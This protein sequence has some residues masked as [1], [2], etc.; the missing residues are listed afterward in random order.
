MEATVDLE[1]STG[2]SH[3][4]VLL[5][6]AIDK[7]VDPEQLGKL[8]DLA[9]RWEANRA[10]KEFDKAMSL[11]QSQMPAILR[12]AENSHTR[13]R[14]ARFESLNAVIRPIYT[15]HG[16]SISFTEEDCPVEG[17]IRLVLDIAH[18]GGCTRRKRIDI[19]LD[20][21]GI[22]GNDNMTATQG[23][24]ST[25]SYAK[26]GLMKMVFNLAETDEDQDGNS[27]YVSP[28][29]IQ[30]INDL[31]AEYQDLSDK[32]VNIEKFLA[33]LGVESLDRLD[34]KGYQKAIDDLK[35]K[36]AAAKREVA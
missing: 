13:S 27:Q 18:E 16:F 17:S 20:G 34:K 12:D 15:K 22:K 28:D 19:P 32:K 30:E 1:H 25:I 3:P 10:S 29:Q 31:I 11:C 7:G 6:A 9:E 5:Q 33:W 26:R 8:M 21:K 24:M 14:Y 36:I 4:L 23:K 2:V 35:R